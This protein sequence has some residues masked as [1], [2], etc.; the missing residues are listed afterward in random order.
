M[1]WHG[2]KEEEFEY[3]DHADS[4]TEGKSVVSFS[5]SLEKLNLYEQTTFINLVCEE[6]F[7]ES[8]WIKTTLREEFPNA[9]LQYSSNIAFLNPS[10]SFFYSNVNPQDKTRLKEISLQALNQI[11]ENG[12]EESI[13]DSFTLTS[14]MEESGEVP[15]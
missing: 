10:F 1:D 5:F 8:S 3:A 6:I 11:A 4:E 7:K 2:Y 12:I 13:L 14:K 9:V 15:R